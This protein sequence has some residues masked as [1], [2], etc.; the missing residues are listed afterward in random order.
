MKTITQEHFTFSTGAGWYFLDD[1]W[2]NS[3]GPY[4]NEDEAKAAED[5]MRKFPTW[6][7][8]YATSK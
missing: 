1:R 8:P 6:G 4:K 7:V 5:M 2:N 3:Y